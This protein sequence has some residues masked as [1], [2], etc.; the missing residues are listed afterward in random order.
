MANRVFKALATISERTN[1][2]DE[3]YQ[4][5]YPIQRGVLLAGWGILLALDMSL[6]NEASPQAAFKE[7]PVRKQIGIRW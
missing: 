5:K 1:T 3:T 7:P 6:F 2:N 4:N